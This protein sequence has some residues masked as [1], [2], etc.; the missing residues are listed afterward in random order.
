[1]LRGF[2]P[3]ISDSLLSTNLVVFVDGKAGTS[4]TGSPITVAD[5]SLTIALYAGV[6]VVAA[7]ALFRARDVT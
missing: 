5:A 2:I 4:E 3:G 1:L 7:L 6:L